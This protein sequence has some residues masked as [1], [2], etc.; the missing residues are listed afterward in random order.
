MKWFD[1]QA[2]QSV[3]E[4]AALLAQHGDHARILAGGTD[5]LVQMRA[6]RRQAGLIV[7]VKNIPELTKISCDPGQGLTLGAAAPCY[8]IAG[9]ERVRNLYPSLAEVASLIGGTQIQGR[10]S[11]GGNL[12]NAAP[13]ADAVP[14]LIALSATCKIAGPGGERT[15]AVED[16]CTGP[17][18]NALGPGELLVSLHLPAP[19][20]AQGARYLRF[21]PRNEMDIAVAGA[22]V[23]VV[24]RD[25]HFES[26]RIAL[27]A[28]APTPLFVREAGDA[29]AGQAVNDESIARAASIARQAARPITDMRGTIEYRRH[30]CEVLT[31][32]ALQE[33]VERARK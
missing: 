4:A 22:G 6:G 13:S 25:G 1:Y 18:R 21:I 5:L 27:A 19:R 28:V 15:I 33:A 9:D 31:R 24:L 17:G 23:S 7:D 30:L 2:P 10:A 32:R 3:G 20:A 16:F 8:Q 26:A 12:C 11:I 29:L 14:L